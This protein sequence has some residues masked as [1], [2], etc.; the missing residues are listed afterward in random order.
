VRFGLANPSWYRCDL[1]AGGRHVTGVHVVLAIAPTNAVRTDRISTRIDLR[2]DIQQQC[3]AFV[4]VVIQSGKRRCRNHVVHVHA[5]AGVV[6][7]VA[8][9]GNFF[10]FHADRAMDRLHRTVRIIG[11]STGG[12]SDREREYAGVQIDNRVRAAVAPTHRK[13]CGLGRRL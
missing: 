1:T 4:E 13:P 2:S 9:I 6:E 7:E 5:Q 8:R 11:I 3:I 12:H 10:N